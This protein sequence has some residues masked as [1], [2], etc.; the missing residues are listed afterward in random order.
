VE[1][2]FLVPRLMPLKRD[3]GFD[4]RRQDFGQLWRGW[5]PGYLLKK[6]DREFQRRVLEV[7]PEMGASLKH[8]LH[9]ARRTLSVIWDAAA[10]QSN[11]SLGT[12]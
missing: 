11:G 2:E 10:A 5:L 9:Q 7:A 1:R 3:G 4:E 12:H 6:F 8:S